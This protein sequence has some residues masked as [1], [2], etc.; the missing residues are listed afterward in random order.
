MTLTA[1]SALSRP[2]L[3][4]LTG[5]LTLAGCSGGEEDTDTDTDTSSTTAPTSTTDDTT[6]GTATT[7]TTADSE[8]TAMTSS[9][10]T[11]D[12]DTD[13][14][15]TTGDVGFCDPKAQDCPEGFKCTAT[16]KMAGDFWNENRCVP[17]MGDGGLGDPCKVL[18]PN[19]PG[20]GT[21]D[22]GVGFIC[23]NFDDE[24]NGA[25]TEF[26]NPDDECSSG[27]GLCDPLHQ[28]G[29]P[30]DLPPDLRSPQ[31]KLSRGPGL[32]RRSEPAGLRLLRPRSAGLARH[33]ERLLR[34]H[35]PVPRRLPLRRPG[36]RRQLRSRRGRLL[37]P[38]LRHHRGPWPLRGRRVVRRLLR[39]SPAAVHGRRDLRDPV[40]P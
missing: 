24:L 12:T 27:K 22:C 16:N 34:L 25:C 31:P 5:A 21:D 37:H 3:L 14:D 9:S 26:C 38:L 36:H 19:E 4:A 35:Q 28:R 33:R 13:T 2:L 7:S 8:T 40:T 23:L 30:A 6:D 32:L 15:S 17:V 39:G 18:D 1:L 20:G 29:H 11:E 10:T